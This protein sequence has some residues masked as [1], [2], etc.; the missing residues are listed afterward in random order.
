MKLGGNTFK[1]SSLKSVA[2]MDGLTILGSAMF[3]YTGL[4]SVSI[5]STVTS[6]GKSFTFNHINFILSN[7]E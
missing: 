7:R 6:I 1:L 2:L 3:S 4:S 5:P